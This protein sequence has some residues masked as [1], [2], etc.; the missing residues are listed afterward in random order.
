MGTEELG[1]LEIIGAIVHQLTRNLTE[2]QIKSAGFDSYFVDHTAG[3]YPT[4]ASGFPWSTFT[5]NVAGCFLI[6]LLTA[7][8]ARQ[9]LSADIRLLLVVGFCGGFTTFSTFSN[10]A[11]ALMRSGETVLFALYLAGSIVAGLLAVWA[12]SFLVRG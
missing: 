9:S 10:E 1:H 12:G 11:L 6:G 8:I 3:V 7:W 2:D 4:A 5:V